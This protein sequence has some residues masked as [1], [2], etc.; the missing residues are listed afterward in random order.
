[1]SQKV[2]LNELELAYSPISNYAF[3]FLKKESIIQQILSHSNLYVIAQR[4]IM[5]FENIIPIFDEQ[6]ISFEIH[7]KGTNGFLKV[8]LPFFQEFIANDKSKDVVFMVGSHDHNYKP[9]APPFKNVHGIRF[10]EDKEFLVWFSPEKFLQNYWKGFIKADVSGNLQSF[11]KYRVHYV[12]K[13]TKQDIWKRLTGHSSLQEILSVEYPLNYGDLPTH[14]IAILFYKFRD[15]L[16]V[17]TWDGNE[18][19]IDSMVASLLGTDLP[20]QE[21]IFLDAEKALIKVMSPKYNREKYISYPT[22]NDGLYKH[23][24]DSFSY[25]FSDPIS[26]EYDNNEIVGNRNV[27]RGDAIIIKNNE[28][29]E[30]LKED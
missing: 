26:L 6:A 22:S 18:E 28:I 16:Q 3:N 13:A 1:M 8:K 27:M 15:N 9:S 25:T 19:E 20:E 14:E 21:T 29:V 7:Q 17:R 24:Y 10:Y 30:L 5:S 11:T 2:L 23:K 4:P 12:G